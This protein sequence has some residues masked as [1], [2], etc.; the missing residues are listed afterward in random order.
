MVGNIRGVAHRDNGYRTGE[1][2]QPHWDG[3]LSALWNVE[4]LYAPLAWREERDESK[5][6]RLRKRRL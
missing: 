3:G 6:A 5:I 1:P 2:L 4:G